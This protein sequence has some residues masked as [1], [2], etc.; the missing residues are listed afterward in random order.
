MVDKLKILFYF[1]IFILLSIFSYSAN[2][3][4]IK[5]D[6]LNSVVIEFDSIPIDLSSSL[7]DS[8]TLIS[9]NTGKYSYNE[10]IKQL[11]G[12]GIISDVFIKNEN[13]NTV[14]NIK[15]REKKGY[16]LSFH[17]F[18]NKIHIDVFQWEKLTPAEEEYRTGL[19]AKQDKI[20]V[21]MINSLYLSSK[22][23]FEEAAFQLGNAYLE[24]GHFKQAYDAYKYAF[25][26]DTNNIDA[27]AGMA[28]SSYNLNIP[29]EAQKYAELFKNKCKC[30][31]SNSFNLVPTS[32]DS[33]FLD[34][35]HLAVNDSLNMRPDTTLKTLEPSIK[36]SVNNKISKN[37][38]FDIFSSVESFMIYVII[39]LLSTLILLVVLYFKWRKKQMESWDKQ[40]Q[41]TFSEN[42]KTAVAKV[43]PDKLSSLYKS[44]EK[45]SSKDEQPV[46]NYNKYE[47]SSIIDDD[48]LNK[49]NTVIESIT[50][51]PSGI[52]KQSQSLPPNVNAK[53]QLAMHLA[54][55]QKKI[56]SLNIESLKSSPIPS[57]KKKLTEISKKLGIEK[58]GLETKAA[59]EKLIK[60][61]DKLKKLSDKFGQD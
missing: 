56:K 25:S 55:E 30:E 19:L 50:G 39:I 21:E 5:I 1:F 2:I 48:K 60:D 20:Y 24:T 16:T 10:K 53:L 49:L 3:K 61:K 8:K 35:A 34:L 7:S 26:K 51:K 54:D 37:E 47:Q 36:D 6:P 40:P 52:I 45:I 27:L 9:I 44:D 43:N 33:S 57:D 11:S 12:L 18:T 58:G 4:N 17:P 13:N 42:L 31:F 15:T 41:T 38:D 28:I 23:G 46:E 29:F 14:I 32:I 59:L 22:N